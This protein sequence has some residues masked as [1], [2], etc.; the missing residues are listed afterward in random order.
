MKKILAF[1]G[2]RSEY[3]LLYSVYQLL[4]KDARFELK[5]VV[6]GSHLSEKYGFTVQY[7]ERDGFTISSRLY[8]LL[9]S[10]SKIGRVISLGSQINLIAHSIENEKPDIVIVAGDR[11]E[12]LS[13]T[14]SCAYLSVPVAHFF[15]GD[16]AKD[17]NVDNSIRYAASKLAHLHFV[18]LPEHKENLIKM[19]EDDWR[20]FVVGNPAIDRLIS[21]PH[22]SKQD[23]LNSFGLKGS[24]FSYVVLIQH[25]IISETDTQAEKIRHTLDAI[26]E[27][28]IH[29]FINYPNSDA[30]NYE[31]I[32]AYDEYKGKYPNQITVFQN[33]DRTRYV[34]LLRHAA[35]LLG[36]SSS[37]LLEAPSLGLPAINIGQRQRGRKAGDNVIFVDN[38]KSEIL[39][40][41]D[42][43]VSNNGLLENLGKRFNPY[44]DGKSAEKI[45]ETLSSISI[46]DNLVYKNI[47]Y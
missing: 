10:D 35:C 30:G 21:T 15:G 32:R 2:S 44:G 34:N 29:C 17:G 14:A 36:N 40:A 33:L 37:G 43:V 46:D 45:I 28:G 31:I 6:T 4:E 38:E 20:I 39:S 42:K 24:V 23:L 13:V 11:E 41:L 22:I 47:T 1:T 27:Y 8:N 19:G 16:I 18:T 7:I 26:I 25:P 9:D 5:L 3:D 12:A